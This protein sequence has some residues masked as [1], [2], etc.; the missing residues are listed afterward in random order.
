MKVRMPTTT[1]LDIPVLFTHLRKVLTEKEVRVK[2]T[3]IDTIPLPIQLELIIH[4]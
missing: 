3:S 4:M 2:R 1:A